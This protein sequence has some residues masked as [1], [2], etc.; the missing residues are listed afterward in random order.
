MRTI[1]FFSIMINLILV[2]CV[3]PPE[4]NDGLLENIPAIINEDDYFSIGLLGDR[5]T[6][7][8]EW[9]LLMEFSSDIPVWYTI[10]S[11]DLNITS[12]DSNFLYLLNAEGIL[13]RNFDFSKGEKNHIF[14]FTSIDSIPKKVLLQSNNFTGRIEYRIIQPS[15]SF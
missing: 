3:D 5:Y 15:S 2:S 10:K 6:K 1:I 14:Q 12:S 4:Y 9:E 8:E 13:I 7:S 11:M